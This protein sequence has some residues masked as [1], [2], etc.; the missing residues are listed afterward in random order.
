[1]SMD[2]SMSNSWLGIHNISTSMVFV[3]VN[4][5]LYLILYIIYIIVCAC[6][7]SLQYIIRYECYDV[8]KNIIVKM[9]S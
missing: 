5:D 4:Y 3:M 8:I 1:M 6:I 2:Y 9:S 7:I